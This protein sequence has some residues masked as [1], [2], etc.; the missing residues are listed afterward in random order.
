MA[1]KNRVTDTV[2]PPYTVENVNAVPSVGHDTLHCRMPDA[3]RALPLVM[4]ATPVGD[5]G[6]QPNE[7]RVRAR[8]LAA[9]S[10]TSQGGGSE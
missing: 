4:S 9:L 6:N 2:G 7:K 8:L 10:R 5:E 1:R 3:A